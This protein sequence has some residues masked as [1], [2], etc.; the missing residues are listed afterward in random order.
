MV[1]TKV[2]EQT[3]KIA[4]TTTKARHGKPSKTISGRG[5]NDLGDGTNNAHAV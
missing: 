4:A 1:K 2:T 3:K 5:T